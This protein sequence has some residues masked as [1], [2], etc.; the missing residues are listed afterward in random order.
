MRRRA[1]AALWPATALGCGCPGLR[2]LGV[3]EGLS[4]IGAG[5]SALR[6]RWIGRLET[7]SLSQQ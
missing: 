4:L 7:Q 1:T 3:G 2:L 5:L 6:G